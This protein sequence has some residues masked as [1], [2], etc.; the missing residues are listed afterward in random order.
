MRLRL[1]NPRFCTAKRPAWVSR[2]GGRMRQHIE[3]DEHGLD[4]WDQRHGSRCFVS[5]VNTAQWGA[6]TGEPPADRAA[7]G[8]GVHGARPSLVRTLRQRPVRA[9]RE[10]Q[11]EGTCQ[12]RPTRKGDGE[13]AAAG[14]RDDCRPACRRARRSDAAPGPRTCCG[15]G[16]GLTVRRSGPTPG[17]AS[18]C[19][20]CTREAGST[21]T[22][23]ISA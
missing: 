2:P 5:I 18:S 12:H 23:L 20:A 19:S 3:E 13:G 4:A 11:A 15:R 1:G 8:G 6:I 22:L 7:H 10:R 9:R 14:Q 21:A 17:Q 16:L